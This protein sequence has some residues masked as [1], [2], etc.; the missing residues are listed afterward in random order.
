MTQSDPTLIELMS[1]AA[2]DIADHFVGQAE[3]YG[4]VGIYGG[5]FIAQALSA[6]LATVDEPKLTH[7]LHCYFLSQGDPGS[8]IDYQVTRLREGRGSDVRS[9]AASQQGRA[10][11]QMT[12]SFKL[13]EDGDQRQIQMPTAKSP[14]EVLKEVAEQ[15]LPFSP[16]PTLKGRTDLLLASEHFMPKTFTSGR[17]PE[18]KVW[19]RC[20]ESENLSQRQTQILLSFV[21]DSTL[22]FTSV[23]PHGL[24]FKTH[25]LTSIDHSAWFHAPC[26]V[27]DWLFYH[28]RSDAAWDGRGMNH[29]S[30]FSRD[31]QL[32]MTTAQE[33]ML[34]KIA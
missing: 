26:D 12:A 20:N 11:F 28:Q 25:R 9:I 27:S 22:M 21:C 29:G 17:K 32:A 7:S 10:V 19:T 5:H 14:E 23:L 4:P 18:L 1:V 13:A 6:G 15:P 2:T 31:G 30:I 33:S 8:P 34:R 24:P 16:P 3:D